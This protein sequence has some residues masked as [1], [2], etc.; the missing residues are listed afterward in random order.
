MNLV[1][2]VIGEPKARQGFRKEESYCCAVLAEPAVG[3]AQKR[4][5]DLGCGGSVSRGNNT[6]F[7]TSSWSCLRKGKRATVR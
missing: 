6:D 2:V 1:E 5:L 4:F 3:V 7:L